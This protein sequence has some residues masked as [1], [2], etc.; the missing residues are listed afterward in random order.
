VTDPL[1]PGPRR[2]GRQVIPRPDRVRPGAPPPWA[3]L[4][5]A[6]R[7]FGLAEL[8]DAFGRLGP[9]VRSPR[10]GSVD[11]A[12]AVLA[13]LYEHHDELHVVLTRRAADLRVHRGEV[14]FPGG[15][16]DPGEDLWGTAL[17]EAAEEVALDGSGVELL[18]ELDH[19]STVS[20]DSFIAPYVAALPG[21][22]ELRPN[23]G[24][25][26]AVLHVPVRELLDHEREERWWFGDRYHPIVFFDLV[27]DTVWGATAAMLRQLLGIGTGT[28][29]R[30]DLG[31]D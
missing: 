18:G 8:R 26:D 30:G 16:Q 15:R 31:H 12:A 20:S 4:S 7:R 22:P 21:R 29:G 11:R 25:V 5:P 2:V 19:L 27:G 3:E 9:P 14:A 17:R 1:D 10:E 28:L 13:A 24:E 23:P 6:E